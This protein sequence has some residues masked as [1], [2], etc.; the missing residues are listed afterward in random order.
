MSGYYARCQLQAAADHSEDQERPERCEAHAGRYFADATKD[1]K[2]VFDRTMTDLRGLDAP[3]YDRARS[4]AL[5][6]FSRS[7][8]AARELCE[9]TFRELMATGEL[10]EA[11]SYKWDELEIGRVMQAA[12]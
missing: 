2:A 12:E 4:A 1:Q 7:T 5:S 9:E 8:A 11:T 6:E 3:R 10:S